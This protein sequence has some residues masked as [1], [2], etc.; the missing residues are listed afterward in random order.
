MELAAASKLADT[1]LMEDNNTQM[2][3]PT[4]ESKSRQLSGAPSTRS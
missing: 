2:L 4:G 3:C 1:A